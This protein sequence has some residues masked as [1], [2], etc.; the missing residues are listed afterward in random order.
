MSENDFIELGSDITVQDLYDAAYG[1]KIVIPDTVLKMVGDRRK[2]LEGLLKS[3]KTMY[4]I[5]TGF[6]QLASERISD[7]NLKSLQ[8]NLI[9]SHSCGVGDPLSE[10][11]VRA[12]M[13]ARANELAH[14][15]SG[16][17]PVVIE[18]LVA[19][20][21]KNVIPY[22]PSKGSVGAS[23]DLAPSAHMALTMLGEGYACIAG[24]DGDCEWKPSAE[25]MK[26]AGI[27][28]IELCEKEGLALI[29]GTQAMK[30]VGGLALYR[31]IKL[32]YNAVTVGA[33]TVEALKGTPVAFDERIHNL[34]PHTGQVE[35]AEIL[36]ELLK[37]SE[38]RK[39]HDTNDTRVQD[40]YCLRCMPQAMGAVLDTLDYALSVFETELVSVTDNPLIVDSLNKK[41]DID[42]LS[43]GNFHGQPLSFAADF[44][45]I[46]MTALGN[47]SE[48]RISQMVSN[49]KILPPFLARNPGLESGFMI[50]HV[51]AAALC[52]ENKILSHP[53]S[54]DSIPTSANQEDFVSM[55]MNAVLKL[56]TVVQNTARIIAIESLSAAEG[57]EYHRPL[58][59]SESIE[60]MLEELRKTAPAFKG[61][62]I[63]SDKIEDVACI[64][65]TD[66]D[67]DSCDCG[68]ECDCEC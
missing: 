19:M 22:I 50:A 55:G 16:V 68:C 15:N 65:M 24:E 28:V 54:A 32:F 62:E 8:V 27:K 11:E 42:V 23:G 41:G 3:G 29:N 18:T 61:D 30:A 49:F 1:K 53:A 14:G 34:K 25:I 36:T 52:N 67:D 47:M 21:N 48:R 57:I 64:L 13:F 51:T 2:K 38:I 45:T 59:S 12:L 60:Y 63:F 33:M 56:S 9:R 40:P 37:D 10:E 20:L 31:A 58:K 46:A 7:E 26:E 4:G 17:R 6:G 39:S 44:A 66:I 5:N 43:G 35:V